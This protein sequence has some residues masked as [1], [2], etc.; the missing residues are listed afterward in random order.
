MVVLTGCSHKLFQKPG[1]WSSWYLFYQ[2]NIVFNQVIR[3]LIVTLFVQA[4]GYH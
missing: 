1:S 4:S 2:C 3:I